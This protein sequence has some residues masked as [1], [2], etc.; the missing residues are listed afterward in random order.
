MAG[1][2]PGFAESAD[3]GVAEWYYARDDQRVGPL[4][5]AEMARLIQ[6]AAIGGGT[7]VWKNGF[8]AWTPLSQTELAA[9]LGQ[10]GGG[11]GAS[12]P[13][14]QPQHG[15][16]APSQPYGQP[17]YGQG[18][19]APPYGQPQYGQGAPSQP[20]GQPQYGQGAS[21]P[22]YGQPQYGQ[23][24]YGQPQGY[25]SASPAQGGAMDYVKHALR[26]MF[27]FQTRASRAEYWWTALIV[28]L[29]GAV[30]LG[31][32]T[33]LCFGLLGEEAGSIAFLGLTAVFGL[34]YAICFLG[35]V[36]RRFHDVGLS[37]WYYLLV[38]VPYVGSIFVFVIA[39]IPSKTPNKYGFGPWR[40]GQDVF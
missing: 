3:G 20:Y 2:R 28:G 22:P 1:L 32:V 23:A 9:H 10:F 16:G 14:E 38:F 12:K 39:V 21:A 4:S 13:L 25:P 33:A 7:L 19:S 29:G 27:D 35:L 17:Q 8:A 26:N 18:A 31:I 6:T 30:A 5:L 15:P 36:V 37:G 11:Q 40:P 34:G 24:P